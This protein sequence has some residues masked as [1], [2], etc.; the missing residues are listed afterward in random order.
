MHAWS[1][2]GGLTAH[3]EY[4]RLGRSPEVRCH[5]Y[6]E[7]FRHPLSEADLHS[8]RKSAHYCQPVGD[9]RF[10]QPIEEKYGIRLGQMKRGRPRS[11]TEE[12]VKT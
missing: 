5:A 1:D 9:D 4:L 6:R 8:I 3:E 12:L 10:R 7:L 11:K 2:P